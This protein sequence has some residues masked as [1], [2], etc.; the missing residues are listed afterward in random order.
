MKTRSKSRSGAKTSSRTSSTRSLK[1]A[2]RKAAKAASRAKRSVTG[3]AKRAAAKV[4]RAITRVTRPTTKRLAT[5]GA[6]TKRVAT[7]RAAKKR[8]GPM[9]DRERLHALLEGFPTVMLVT[10]EARGAALRARPMTV[11][12]LDESCTMSFLSG[13]APSKGDE[14]GEGYAGQVVA[15]GKRTFL[16]LGGR[17]EVVRDR[18]R[19]E[20]A[21]TPA[22][23][24]WFPLGKEDPDL[25][26]LVF[27]PEN[28]EIWDVKGTHGLKYLFEAAKA[29]VTG[30]H[31]SD[32]DQEMHDVIDLRTIA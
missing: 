32:D 20:A 9:S 25:R 19:I 23:K 13:A 10:S 2:P 11:A 22:D 24:A 5:K 29:L 4:S 30:G 31:P 27:R 15:Q 21:W 26:L 14:S 16:S 7:K 6:A 17:I 28:A 3:A 12:R 1:G 8:S 18:A